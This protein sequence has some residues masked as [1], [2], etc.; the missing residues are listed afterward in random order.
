M[1]YVDGPSKV[2]N[3]AGLDKND[4]ELYLA[5]GCKFEVR[6][7]HQA[8]DLFNWFEKNQDSFCTKL[9]SRLGY[10]GGSDKE[11]KLNFKRKSGNLKNQISL[12]SKF[13][14]ALWAKG[15]SGKDTEFAPREHWPEFRSALTEI[16]GSFEMIVFD[17]LKQFKDRT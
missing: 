12:T 14:E 10:N 11:L 4:V 5:A 16:A 17:E 13:L 15:K 8:I 6:I 2:G 7:K 9:N 1:N 3:E